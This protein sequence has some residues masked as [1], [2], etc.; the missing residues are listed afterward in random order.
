MGLH[1][2]SKWICDGIVHAA[3]Q[4]IKYRYKVKER[5]SSMTAYSLPVLN[6]LKQVTGEWYQIINTNPQTSSH[7]VL[8][9]TNG[10][11]NEACS[12]NPS[13]AFV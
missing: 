1:P 6:S 4:L 7:W 12:Y 3:S 11:N 9:T 5:T 2:E 13:S 10:F 8:L